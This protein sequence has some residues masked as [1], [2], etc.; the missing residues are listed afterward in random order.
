MEKPQIKRRRKLPWISALGAAAL[1]GIVTFVT[2]APKGPP[3]YRDPELKPDEIF[4]DD[5]IP[6]ESP[7]FDPHLV[8]ARKYEGWDINKSSAVLRLDIR[9]IRP[10]KEANLEK[11]YP[12]YDR[13]VSFGGKEVIPSVSLLDSKCKHFDDSL[14]AAVDLAAFNGVKGRLVG[15]KDILDGLRKK[16]TGKAAAFLDA[17]L[18]LA[19]G[20]ALTTPSSGTPDQQ[21]LEA[22]LADEVA[23]RPIG[24]YNWNKELQTLYRTERFLAM[25]FSDKPAVPEALAKAL[26]SDPK[27]LGDYRKFVGLFRKL[28]NAYVCLSLDQIPEGRLTSE[29]LR[30]AARK[31]G[32]RH[33]T[34][35]FLPPSTCRENELFER[36]GLASG[37]GLM[38]EFIKRIMKGEIDLA[39]RKD[40]GWYEHQV[41]ALETLLLPGRG[42][43]KGKLIFS[44]R[45]KQRML[46]SF[47]AILTRRRETHARGIP[48]VKPA[49][50]AVLPSGIKI[51]PRIRIEPAPTYYL[52]TA[53][54][55][56]FVRSLLTSVFGT[57]LEDIYGIRA[58][59]TYGQIRNRKLSERDDDFDTELAFMRQLFYGLYL[60]SCEDIGLRPKF[61]AGEKVDVQACRQA[62]LNWIESFR[63]DPDLKPDARICVPISRGAAGVTHWSVVGVRLARLEVEY[64]AAPSIRRAGEKWQAVP[65]G[66]LAKSNYL[67][68][69]DAFASFTLKKG[70]LTRKEF[71]DALGAAG[72]RDAFLEMVEKAGTRKRLV[73]VVKAKAEAQTQED[74]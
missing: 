5:P 17:A 19:S 35:S 34:V 46:E 55:Y 22:F 6:A 53:R 8:D 2:C 52:R 66:S 73:E 27:L 16:L 58:T 40:A 20:K 12:T 30:A 13:A 49:K 72:T 21:M 69:V 24:F 11:I 64:V 48:P 28:T 37:N 26:R 51:R 71:W 10:G 65:H 39:P 9:P 36:L 56:D 14:Y 1:V 63:R 38:R 62:G 31:H 4:K 47:K 3:E 60:V 68:P 33:P 67:I 44:A 50:P 43:E 32:V 57:E 42:Q 41:F 61:S 23:S 54:A 18:H 15:L 7:S 25:E 70:V 59:W 45:Y 29:V 74:W